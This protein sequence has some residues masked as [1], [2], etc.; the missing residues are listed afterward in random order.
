MGFLQEVGSASMSAEVGGGRWSRSCRVYLAQKALG[1][2][3]QGVLEK[4]EGGLRDWAAERGSGRKPEWL[5]R[6]RCRRP[7]RRLHAGRQPRARSPGV[8][9]QTRW[10]IMQ[11]RLQ[12]A[13]SSTA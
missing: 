10:L 9:A 4:P 8:R 7:A 1:E 11:A 6:L 13:H 3:E 12:E 2:K 5:S